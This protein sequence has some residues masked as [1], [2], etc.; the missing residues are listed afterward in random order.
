MKL[1]YNLFIQCIYFIQFLRQ[2]THQ[3]S[4]Y[5]ITG[6]KNIFSNLQHNIAK[7]SKPIIWLHCASVGEFEQANPIIDW[8][9]INEPGYQILVSF[10]SPSGYEL[11]KNKSN[12]FIV[13]YLPLDTKK[14]A[15]LFIQMINPTIVIFI[16]YEFWY[17][18]LSQLYL[19][20][21]P[22]FLIDAI[23]RKNQLFFKK[24][25][26]F[27]KNILNY[28]TLIFV[29]DNYSYQLLCKINLQSKSIIAGDTRFDQV[30]SFKNKDYSNTIIEKFSTNKFTFIAGSIY[31]ADLKVILPIIKQNKH[32]QFIL[33][34]HDVSKKNIQK[35]KY[36]LPEAIVY[37]E[38][39]NHV[40]PNNNHV[41]IIDMVGLLNKLYRYGNICYIGG[42]FNKTGIH[43]ILEAVI[44]E[45]IVL[46]GPNYFKYKEAVDIIQQNGAY[47]I[48]NNDEIEKIITLIQQN[49]V[50][51]IHTLNKS[52]QFIQQNLSATTFIMQ[53]LKSTLY[54]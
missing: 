31:E 35:F 32:I 26:S 5:W 51:I 11:F 50:K 43:N 40:L 27:Y 37:T 42:G 52:T 14:N 47:C 19:N 34:P 10:F 41:L 39:N 7:N 48:K 29:Q 17:H 44:Y 6:Q 18:Y 46:F 2:F 1:V 30:L 54:L 23:F 9:R 16:K 53:K 36:Y 20:K 49:D 24:Y 12:D 3:K 15:Q 21:I 28:F 38:I 22:V 13:T 4:A 33:V 25:T 8:L 45:K